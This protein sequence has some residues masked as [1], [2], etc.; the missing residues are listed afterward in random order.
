MRPATNSLPRRLSGSRRQQRG[1]T[2]IIALLFLSILAIL[3][4]TSISGTTAEEKMS[5]NTRDQN[6]AMQ[7]AEAALRDAERDITNTNTSFRVVTATSQFVA[8]CTSALCAQGAATTNLDDTL[9]SA[10]YG[11]FTGE[12]PIQ[13]PAAQPR[14]MIELLTAVPPQVPAPAS[15]QIRNFRITAKGYGRNLA[16]VVILQTVYQMTL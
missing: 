16:T 8:A 10:Y 11:Q 3:G 2:L 12:L 13:G 4:V 15:G 7:A 1:A 14:Y 6:V 9:K 5:A